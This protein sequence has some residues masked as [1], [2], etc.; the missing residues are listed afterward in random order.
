MNRRIL[1]E[2]NHKIVNP[3][4]LDRDLGFDP[5]TLPADHD[6]LSPPDGF[7]LRKIVRRDIKHL[8]RCEAIYL[9]KGWERSIG[10]QAEKAVADWL[11]LHTLFE[12]TY[13]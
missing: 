6:W 12:V 4:D 11:Q 7:S 3:A 5:T 2:R 8:T 9:L 1:P 13:G 10:A